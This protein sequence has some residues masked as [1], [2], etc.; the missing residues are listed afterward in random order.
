MS[1]PN[2]LYFDVSDEEDLLENQKKSGKKKKRKEKKAV[3]PSIL[4]SILFMPLSFFFIEM[5]A[6]YFL[7]DIGFTYEEGHILLSSLIVS[8]LLMFFISFLPVKLQRFLVFLLTFIFAAF[9]CAHLVYANTFHSFFSWNT[10]GIA[11]DV[12]EFWRETLE[13]IRKN[14]VAIII[15]LLPLVLFIILGKKYDL[16]DSPLLQKF[17]YLLAA[18][19]A[20]TGLFLMILTSNDDTK[21]VKH[22]NN[23]ISG[24]YK[25]FGFSTSTVIDL[26]HCIYGYEEEVIINPYVDESLREMI[27]VTMN[28]EEVILKNALNIDFEALIAA[29]PNSTIKDMS[30][31][32]STVPASNQNDYT[33]L[34]EGKNLIFL[35]LE[36]F[37]YKVIDPELT[38]TLYKLYTEGFVFTN[39][40]DSLWGGSTATGE[41][42]N[43]TGNFYLTANCLEKSAST[44][45]Y[46]AMGN[47]FKNSGYATYAYHNNTYTYYSRDK[48]HPNFGY[49]WKAVGNG[50]DIAGYWP[51]SDYE[52]ATKTVKEYINSEQPFHTYYMTVS[53]HQNYTWI[54]NSMS[55][56]HYSE[57]SGLKYSENVKAYIACNLEVEKMLT[58]IINQLDKAG[59]LEDTVIA[60]CCDHYPYGLSDSELAELYGLSS[61][62]VRANLELYRNSFI[63]WSAS[64]EEPVVV[65]TPCSSIDIVPT[66]ANLFGISYDSRFITGTDI[67]SDSENIA[68]INT[69]TAAGG[70]DNW[71]TTEGTYYSAKKKFV[72]SE[73]CT[74]TDEEIEAYV[75]RINKKVS[76]MRK[77]SIAILNNNYYKYVF[78]KD[79]TPK[80]VLAEDDNE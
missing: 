47:L 66:L 34:F 45:Q 16:K 37:S 53:G 73:T 68:L 35:T 2:N 76:A 23:N 62:N 48:S 77:Y 56:R 22:M 38:P 46:S 27:D 42:S 79:G 1:N 7:F 40:Y 29:S 55:S 4:F 8:L 26:Y 78:N 59:I 52:M 19:V 14:G 54:G 63:L 61:S 13:A 43:M 17:L 74:M 12:T 9:C 24:T 49:K 28:E 33:G 15:I 69:L 67:L 51:R 65:D 72:K 75:A 70:D 3:K 30:T 18:I 57:V 31:Y 58:Y 36:G 41:Y 39:F 71:V 6:R 50:L 21:L 44:L 11:G 80:Y 32:F 64:M 60:M 25:S 20:A 5:A 10:I